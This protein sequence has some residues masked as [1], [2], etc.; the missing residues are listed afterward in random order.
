MGW[1]I[2]LGELVITG[3]SIGHEQERPHLQMSL[4]TSSYGKRLNPLTARGEYLLDEQ[5]LP[6]AQVHTS[7]WGS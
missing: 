5:L 4:Q 3:L 2:T 6:V 1:V 7:S